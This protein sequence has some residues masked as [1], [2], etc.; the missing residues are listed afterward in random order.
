MLKFKN[1][2]T[3]YTIEINIIKKYNF[4]NF[5]LIKNDISICITVQYFLLKMTQNTSA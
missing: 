3:R 2:D 1:R 5:R 4:L